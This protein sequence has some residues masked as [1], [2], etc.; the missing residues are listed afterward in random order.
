MPGKKRCRVH[1]GASTGARSLDGKQRQAEG[2]ERY[3]A[4]LRGQQGGPPRATIPARDG[5]SASADPVEHM[6]LEALAS[7]PP[8]GNI[9][10]APASAPAAPWA[11]PPPPKAEPWPEMVTIFDTEGNPIEV[12]VS[13]PEQHR[14]EIDQLVRD[15]FASG[16]LPLPQ[17]QAE[18]P[19]PI[20]AAENPTPQP[21]D[22]SPVPIPMVV[23]EDTSKLAVDVEQIA[24]AAIDQIKE[25]LKHPLDK[26]DPN[27]AALLRF[28]SSTY[29]TSMTTITRTDATRLQ[30]KRESR[31]NF[32]LEHAQEERAK[33]ELRRRSVELIA[34]SAD[35]DGG[36]A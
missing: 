5:A 31:L 4:R 26:Q 12:P 22:V 32:I 25:L 28:L 16:V 24:S 2:R 1:G 30:H 17:P 10:P 23:E 29:N 33:Y 7:L 34:T 6:R 15:L 21:A 8:A 13:P 18:P 36:A 11:I 9:P 35:D 14:R 19:K 20:L 27:F 3:F